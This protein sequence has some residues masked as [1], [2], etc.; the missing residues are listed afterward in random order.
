MYLKNIYDK[1]QSEQTHSQ[2]V[3]QEN[4]EQDRGEMIKKEAGEII[5]DSGGG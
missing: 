5:S 1:E 3:C 4:R 2:K